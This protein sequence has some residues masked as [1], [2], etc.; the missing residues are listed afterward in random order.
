MHYIECTAP[1]HLNGL[2][3]KA[4]QISEGPGPLYQCGYL[5]TGHSNHEKSKDAGRKQTRPKPVRKPNAVQS[6]FPNIRQSHAEKKTQFS[7]PRRQGSLQQ[8]PLCENLSH[9][10]QRHNRS[11]ESDSDASS[12]SDHKI[13]VERKNENRVSGEGGAFG[14]LLVSRG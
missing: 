5:L 11:L 1:T 2:K 12:V 3:S 9:A 7:P 13:S 6:S 10:S 4:I 8:S 14:F